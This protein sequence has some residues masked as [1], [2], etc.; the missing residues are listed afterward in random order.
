MSSTHGPKPPLTRYGLSLAA[1]A[2][3]VVLRWAF[4]PLIGHEVPFLFLWPILLAAAWL[5]GLGPGLLVLLLGTLSVLPTIPTLGSPARPTELFKLC[6]FVSFGGMLCFVCERIRRE[7]LRESEETRRLRDTLAGIVDAVIATD[8]R[9]R[10][11]YLNPAAEALTGWPEQDAIGLPIGKVFRVY[12]EDKSGTGE[13]PVPAVLAT[14]VSI[15]QAREVVIVTRDGTR[16]EVER[17]AGPVPGADDESNV[18]GCVIVFHDTT[19]RRR[20]ENAVKASEALF[21]RLVE[22]SP[23]GVAITGADGSIAEA[24]D[25]FLQILGFS[26]AELEAGDLWW[27]RLT[28]IEWR[29]ADELA[30]AELDDRGVC[31]PYEKEFLTSDGRRVPVLVGAVLPDDQLVWSGTVVAYCVDLTEQKQAEANLRAADRRKDEFL[32]MLGHELR[33]PLAAVRNAVQ[34]LG[35]THDEAQRGQIRGVLDRQTEH[36]SRVVDDLL[37]VSR[38]ASGKIRL[39][40]QPTELGE[41]LT[42]ASEAARPLIDGRKHRLTLAPIPHPVWVNGDPVR[43]V[44]I[45]A[46]L[47]N[48]AA[49]Y[50]DDGGTITVAV[51]VRP[52]RVDVAVRDSGVGIAAELLSKV[53]DLFE[54]A[55]VSPDRAHG[56]LGLGLTLVR[57]LVEK[58]GGNVVAQSEGPGTGSE[59]VVRLP[60]IPAPEGTSSPSPSANGRHAKSATR[61]VLVVDDNRDSADS[62]AMV[63]ELLGHQV[64]A[65]NDGP[66]ALDAVSG[67]RPDV[68]L[69]DI[70]MPGM[71]GF[72]VARRLRERPD[73]AGLR[74][75]ALTGYGQDEDRRR[76]SEA[77]FDAHLVKPASPESLLPILS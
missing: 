74:L 65:V 33:T 62:L 15:P 35:L 40:P 59:F 23:F 28:P 29:D 39:K 43:L 26:R 27:D 18:D 60:T 46:N 34:A 67:F 75:V 44:Q 32:A 77:G 13:S 69:L 66:A 11:T 3:A 76:T 64:Q 61:R 54:Q 31:E 12:T 38:L 50:T 8:D 16:R 30:R 73:S 21:R 48:N 57:R 5:G 45:F 41:I 24:N 42:R 6:V 70:G 68:V 52:D 72:E 10:V 20:A 49:K 9:G 25:A 17:G 4:A 51:A 19:A 56:G 22:A 7:L 58:H 36:L 37:D 1:V 2:G 55:D 47:L 53:F 71:T 63:L 14:G